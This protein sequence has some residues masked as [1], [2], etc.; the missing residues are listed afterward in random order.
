MLDRRAF[1]AAGFAAAAFAT[2]AHAAPGHAAGSVKVDVSRLRAQGLGP[3]ASRIQAALEQ[4]LAGA[5]APGTSLVVTVRGISMS[6]YAGNA[7]MFGAGSGNDGIDSEVAVIDKAGRVVA[8]YP[9]MS[10]SSPTLAGPWY[11]PGIDQLRLDAMARTN[12]GWIRRY[13]RG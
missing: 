8:Q 11:A 9:I 6:S 1:I 3:N 2:A 13:V 5:A 10:S 7:G 4:E 12:A